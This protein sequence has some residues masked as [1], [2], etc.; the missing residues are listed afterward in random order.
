[1]AEQQTLHTLRCLPRS[2]SSPFS[3]L[4]HHILTSVYGK[5]PRGLTSKLFFFS[6]YFSSVYNPYDQ[7]LANSLAQVQA[8]GL[9]DPRLQNLA[10]VGGLGAA[11]AAAAAAGN[12]AAAIRPAGFPTA[13]TAAG[14][15]AAGAAGIAGLPAG[16]SLQAAVANQAAAAYT[17]G[18]LPAA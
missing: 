12:P 1:M 14:A 18:G 3:D 7:F 8:S 9:A 2:P 15:A 16:L 5:S 4:Y 6:E 17:A 10:A 11:A 13:A